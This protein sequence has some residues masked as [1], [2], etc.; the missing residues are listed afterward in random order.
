MSRANPRFK[1]TNP[2]LPAIGANNIFLATVRGVADNEEWLVNYAYMGADALTAAS[3]QNIATAIDTTCRIAIT[4][5][6][7]SSCTYA[8]VK[9]Q[10]LNVPSRISYTFYTNG[11]VPRPGVIGSTH[12]PKEMSAIISKYTSTKGQHG[13]GRNYW[14]A[15]PVS[16]TTPATNPNNLNATGLAAYTTLWEN[17]NSVDIVDGAVIMYV[18]VYTHVKGNSPVTL[19]QNVA[20][21]VVQP[22]LGTTRRRRPGRGK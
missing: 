17:F 2:P 6:L 22:I 4:G 21:W 9:V 7:D 20:T 15:I 11:G 3:E 12:L 18:S 16:F 8:S 19:A 13:R 10:C 1:R 5:V 14:P